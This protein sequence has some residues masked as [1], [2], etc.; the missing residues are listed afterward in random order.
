MCATTQVNTTRLVTANKAIAHREG[1]WPKEVDCLDAEN[2]IR[3]RKKV[4][5]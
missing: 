4:R 2:V 1:G 3:F 5:Y